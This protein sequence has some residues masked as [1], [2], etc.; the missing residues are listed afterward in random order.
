[1]FSYYAQSTARHEREK[2]EREVAAS[3]WF[4]GEEEGPLIKR[5]MQMMTESRRA[6][7]SASAEKDT[8]PFFASALHSKAGK[9]SRVTSSGKSNF[10]GLRRKDIRRRRGTIGK[11]D[12]RDG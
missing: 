10:W 2:S 12:A 6:H 1:M 8:N 3:H 5:A 9:A 7:A 4:N 11:W